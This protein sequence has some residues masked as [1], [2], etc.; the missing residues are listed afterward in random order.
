M[1]HQ[2]YLLEINESVNLNNKIMLIM[3][4][5]DAYVSIDTYM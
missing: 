2:I 3:L 4:T 1:H 5:F